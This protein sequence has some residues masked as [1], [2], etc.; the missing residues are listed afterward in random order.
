[1]ITGFFGVPGCGKTTMATKLAIKQLRKNKLLD[2]LHLSRFKRYDHV[3]TNFTCKGCEKIDFSDIGV[4]DIT[5]SLIIL[6]ELTIDADNRD[7]KNFKKSSVEGFVYHRHD[8]NDIIYFT[9][10]YDAVDKK[11]RNLTA[12]LY[13][14]KVSYLLPISRARQIFREYK[15]NEFNG[16]LIMG[17]RFASLWELFLDLI[18]F[19]GKVGQI[20][21]SC[22][23]PHWYK[24]FDSFCRPYTRKPFNYVG[25]NDLPHSEVIAAGD[26]IG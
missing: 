1:M 3:L 11:I 4:Y 26:K 10:Q 18:L 24:Y 15:I 7:F 25:W 16:D 17:Y 12:R 21:M 8:N 23:R 19:N 2:K 13:Y 9:Q 5:D 22:F 14:M 6:D 20:N